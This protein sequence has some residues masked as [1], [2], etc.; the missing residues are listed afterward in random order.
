MLVVA[1][2]ANGTRSDHGSEDELLLHKREAHFEDIRM[3]A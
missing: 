3:Y 2:R 1:L